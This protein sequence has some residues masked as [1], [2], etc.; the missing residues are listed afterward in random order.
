MGHRCDLFRRTFRNDLATPVAAFRPQVNYP[1][2][3]LDD[4][5]VMLDNYNRVAMVAQAVEHTQQLF[6]ILEMQSGSWL[7][8]NIECLSGIPLARSLESLM[9]WASP[10]ESVVALCPSVM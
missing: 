5:Q 4:I 2:R 6:D 8:Q 3:G 10:P 7:I 9:R 1:V